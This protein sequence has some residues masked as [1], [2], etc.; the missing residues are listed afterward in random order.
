MRTLALVSVAFVAL[1]GPASAAVM[2][3]VY[4]GVISDAAGA[5]SPVGD[6]TAL[7]GQAF[8][9]TFIYDTAVMTRDTLLSGGIFTDSFVATNTPVGSAS[10]R[11]G[12]EYLSLSGDA[13]YTVTTRSNPTEGNV[14]HY[15]E[16][17]V[18]DSGGTQSFL[19]LGGGANGLTDV[20]LL[21]PL[22][23]EFDFGLGYFGFV[24]V[25]DDNTVE[26]IVGE[27]RVTSVNISPVAPIPLPAEA[28]LMLG[29]LG[30]LAVLRRR[31][32]V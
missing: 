14:S 23:F 28:W 3:A 31:A 15:A 4:T 10:L 30:A 16:D 20:D 6:P 29:G 8:T 22:F 32:T 12:D 11:I 1:S 24:V 21:A 26:S 7:I 9:A 13:I 25:Q 18:V 27:L 17:Y 19:S 2:R 5:N